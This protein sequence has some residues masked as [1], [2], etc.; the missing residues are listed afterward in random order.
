MRP[1]RLVRV[2]GA[3]L[4]GLTAFAVAAPLSA[5]AQAGPATPDV[6]AAACPPGQ[7]AQQRTSRGPSGKKITITVCVP[8]GSSPGQPDPGGPG[9]QGGGGGDND[10]NYTVCTPWSEANPGHD[11]SLLTPGGPGEEAYQCVRYIN[12]APVLGPYLP[13]WLGPDEPPPPPPDVVAADIWADVSG[14]LQDPSVVADPAVGEPA[15]RTVPSFVHVE[16]WQPAFSE[17]GCDDQ[18]GTVCVTVN[19][20]PALTFDPGDGSGAIPCPDG[21]TAYDPEGGTPREQAVEGA[22]FHTYPRRT[23]V[24]GRPDAWEATVTVTWTVTWAGAGQSGTLAPIALEDGFLRE[25]EEVQSV[26]RGSGG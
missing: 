23:G 2:A 13:T 11:P 6:P 19:A 3:T 25:V 21:G 18:T 15:I 20:T 5:P 7:V 26:G 22:C 12:G 24:E 16:N 9:D 17:S 4:L 14:T 1:S 10:G 8:G